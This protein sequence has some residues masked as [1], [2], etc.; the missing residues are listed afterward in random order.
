MNTE[1]RKQTQ[2]VLKQ[3]I[4]IHVKILIGVAVLSWDS[5]NT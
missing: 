5:V 1:H 2:T 4:K 3:P